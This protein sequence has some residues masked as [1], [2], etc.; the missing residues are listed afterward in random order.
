MNNIIENEMKDLG[1]FMAANL[2]E[3]QPF[4][5]YDKHLDCIRVQIRDCSVCEMRLSG[6]I[7]I[8]Q[9]N[10]S[11]TIDYVGFSIKGVR[12]LFETVQQPLE[13]IMTLVAVFDLLVKAYPHSA[14]KRVIDEF[15]PY[16]DK[17]TVNFAEAA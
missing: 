16:G 4:A 10:H 15:T 1:T 14:V 8:L 7:T 11:Q 6:L 9:A 13:G 2:K 17:L 5:Y 12:H 3:F